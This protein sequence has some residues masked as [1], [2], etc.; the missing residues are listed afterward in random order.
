MLKE[1]KYFFTRIN[2]I[3]D[4]ILSAAA[5]LFAH[6]VR[7]YFLSQYIAPNYFYPS[8]FS[9]Y[10]GLFILLPP[11]T[12]IFLYRNRCYEI[13]NILI[14]LESFKIIVWSCI[15]VML[16]F[17]VGIYLFKK[18]DPISRGQIFLTPFFQVILL[19]LKYFILRK[20]LITKS[21]KGYNLETILV[22]GDRNN[23]KNGLKLIQSHPVW[24]FNIV[25]IISDSPEHSN[26]NN[27]IEG[28][29]FVE[30]ISNALSYIEKNSIDQV[31]IIPSNQNL[32]AYSQILEG[33]E[34]MG[35][36]VH[37]LMD[38]YKYSIA[39]PILSF[40]D[41]NPIVSFL[42]VKEMGFEL[43]I[44]YTFDRLAALIL[45]II[46]SP[47]ILLLMAIIKLSSKKNEPIFYIQQR[48]GLNGKIF[49]LYKFRTMKL[50]AD[51]ELDELRK[52]SDI[53][54]PVFKMK[55][56]PRVTKYGKIL[57]K[58]SLDELPQFYNVLKGD[59]SLVGPR[60]PLP[61]EVAKYDR[62]QRRR[63]SMKPGLTC[64][65]QVMGRN[66][67]DFNTWMKL[68]LEYIDNWSLWLDI[69]ILLKTIFVVI[70]GYGAM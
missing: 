45:L 30:N 65:W 19:S 66:K 35:I 63:L 51:K 11:L 4:F 47:V 53:D 70:T 20:S 67:L 42:P 33:C 5:F 59:M 39:H 48:A 28:I 57:R 69:K 50:G 21:K 25:G 15:Q 31:M 49:N 6:L 64:L 55:D 58:F 18:D 36:K 2:L 1:K 44:K 16:I 29:P 27:E 17:I 9:D 54:G 10:F 13:K 56:D 7:N 12:L 40:I 52:H 68:D 14:P 26:S 32:S 46:I 62:W 37:I 41:Y 22:I 23:L 34:M 43:F 61:E 3:I 8:I 38:F 24:K 60:P